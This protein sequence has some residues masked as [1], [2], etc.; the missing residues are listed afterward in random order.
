VK[1]VVEFSISKLQSNFPSH[2]V[3]KAL[4]VICPQYWMMIDFMP[5]IK[6]HIR[7]IKA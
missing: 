5:S 7:M 3:I 1:E 2:G 4:G 6:K